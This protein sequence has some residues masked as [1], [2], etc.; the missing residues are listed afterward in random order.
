M[1]WNI[2]NKNV[3]I[4][5]GTS[6][7][8]F[9]TAK[10]LAAMGAKVFI[11]GRNEQAAKDAVKQIG[12]GAEYFLA[13]LS[14]QKQVRELATQVSNKLSQLD[15][16]INNAGA[17]F[18]AFKLSEDG[19]EMTIATN[20][21]APFLLTHT[22]MPLLE[23][24]PQARIVNVSSD[25]HYQG[26]IDIE[27]FRVNKSFNTMKAYGQSKLANVLFTAALAKRLPAHITAN[28]L[29]PGVVKTH[30]GNK[31]MPSYMSAVWS[32]FT[33]L[34]GI[35]VQKGAATSV[36]LASSAEVDGVSGKYFAKSREKKPSKKAQDG[37][38]A[39]QLWNESIRLCG[40]Q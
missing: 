9:E 12:H 7:I 6:G 29:H 4:T 10:Q 39:E 2:R 16:L 28:S 17:V 31:D 26:N 27:S 3:L 20:H 34:A 23:K 1:A 8:G 5:G 32:L 11:T 18:P 33:A 21:F 15:V 22:L 13:E 14:S 35:S 37:Q 38:L 24:A 19:L 40:L 25:S 30:I 36:Y